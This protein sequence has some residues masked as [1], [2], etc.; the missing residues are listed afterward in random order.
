[1]YELVIFL[2]TRAT[3][4]AGFRRAWVY[5]SCTEVCIYLQCLMPQYNH[6]Y[7]LWHDHHAIEKIVGIH[8]H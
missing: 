2:H 5:T 8:E 1:M 6:T 7:V 4:Y 3:T